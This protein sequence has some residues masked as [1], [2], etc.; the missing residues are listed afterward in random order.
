M[1]T[2]DELKELLKECRLLILSNL[3]RYY[4]CNGERAV[5]KLDAALA[6]DFAVVQKWQ[7]VD[8][9]CFEYL[10]NLPVKESQAFFWL[11][12]SRKQRRKAIFE[13][14]LLAASEGK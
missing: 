3:C 4:D 2:T 14:M 1:M 13:A 10:Q 8:A 11:H 7:E 5:N 9:K 12:E 6:S